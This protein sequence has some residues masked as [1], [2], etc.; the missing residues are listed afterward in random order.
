MCGNAGQPAP[1]LDEAAVEL[2]VANLIYHEVTA[3]VFASGETRAGSS[4]A[5][6]PSG[7]HVI[8]VRA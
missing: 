3:R 8:F 7:R 5:R 2:E 4:P 6:T 1:V